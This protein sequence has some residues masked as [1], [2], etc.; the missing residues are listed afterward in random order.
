MNKKGMSI[1]LWSMIVFICIVGIIASESQKPEETYESLE[2]GLDSSYEN[3]SILFQKYINNASSGIEGTI[4]KMVFKLADVYFYIAINVAKITAKLATENPHINFRMVINLI[5]LL[6]F[7]MIII[8][9]IKFIAIIWI[10]I[11][12]TV[13]HF[14]EKKELKR[15][16]GTKKE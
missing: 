13:T 6:L 15:L 10:L 7:L 1:V 9:L 2:R 16:K 12:D 5:I 3:T 4:I 14:K 8:P 11:Y